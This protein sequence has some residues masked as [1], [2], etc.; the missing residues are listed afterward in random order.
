MPAS[1]GVGAMV[2]AP[3]ATSSQA[4]AIRRRIYSGHPMREPDVWLRCIR[5]LDNIRR[6]HNIRLLDNIRIQENIRIQQQIWRSIY[7]KSREENRVRL[8]N[9]PGLVNNKQIENIR[10]Q[11]TAG[12]VN[13]NRLLDNMR[14]LIKPGVGNRNGLL[15]KLELLNSFRSTYSITKTLKRYKKS[16]HN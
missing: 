9:K 14:L 10:L 6:L 5:L 13:I 11:N 15:H 7:F 16:T 8:L 2:P 12:L 4:K 1:P 3:R